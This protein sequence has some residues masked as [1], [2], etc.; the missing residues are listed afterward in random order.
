[1]VGAWWNKAAHLMVDRKERRERK[2]ERE[3]EEGA[4]Q[5]LA[6]NDTP[7]ATYFLQVGPTS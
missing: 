5:D 4:R 3:R 1:M 6:P 7:T 2:R